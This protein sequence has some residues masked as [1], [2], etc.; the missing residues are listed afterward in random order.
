MIACARTQN[1]SSSSLIFNLFSDLERKD[2]VSASRNA[3]AS[4][5][6]NH[7]ILILRR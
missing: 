3:A 6:A 5:G 1:C 4:G 7:A 2:H